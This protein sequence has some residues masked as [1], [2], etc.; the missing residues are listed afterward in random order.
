MATIR[1]VVALAT[2]KNWVL[3]QLEVNNAFLHK[4]LDKEVYMEVQKGIP[5]P[6]D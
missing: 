6:S 1:S 4:G 5:N 3:S 2:S